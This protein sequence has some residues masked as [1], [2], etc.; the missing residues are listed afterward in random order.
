MA[1]HEDNADENDDYQELT[2]R[3][4]KH[5]TT[6]QKR[7][8]DILQIEQ[9]LAPGQVIYDLRLGE[10]KSHPSGTLVEV[11]AKYKTGPKGGTYSGGARVY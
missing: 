5:Y 1:G 9:H 7:V 10:E 2:A 11:V 8:E 6:D 3:V 4:P